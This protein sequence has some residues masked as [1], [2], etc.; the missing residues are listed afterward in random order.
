MADKKSN[1]PESPSEKQKPSTLGLGTVAT[2]WLWGALL[3]FTP[4]YL[5]IIHPWRILF[6]V[7]GGLGIIIS[8]AGALLEL[9]KLWDSEGLE[10]WGVSLVFMIPA[11]ALYVGVWQQLIDHPFVVPAKIAFLLLTA[12]GG[13]LFFHGVP[14]FFWESGVDAQ[15]PA[16]GD[17]FPEPDHKTEKATKAKLFQVIANV[18]VALLSLATAVVTLV[19]KLAPASTS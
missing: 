5:G 7:I 10:Y 12:V 16:A 4:Q 14:Y 19:S 1:Q 15:H 11:A 2:L 9:G 13:S 17:E 6:F 18:I 8:F 3:L